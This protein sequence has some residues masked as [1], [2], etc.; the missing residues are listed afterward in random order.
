M[1][2]QRP[3]GIGLP[4]TPV[5]MHD[6]N[7]DEMMAPRYATPVQPTGKLKVQLQFGEKALHVIIIEVTRNLLKIAY[8]RGSRGGGHGVQT[9]LPLKEHKNIGFLSITGLDSLKNHRAT[10]LA[11]NVGPPSVR[12]RNAIE[13]A[14]R[15]WTDD[16][17]L[18]VGFFGS[19]L[20]K[21]LGSAHGF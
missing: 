4:D 13:M 2:F 6:L 8:M 18:L 12:Q 5:M 14:F 10:K 19:P 16:G 9:P 1:S 20:A 11:F 21:L 17:P 7:L 15:W 3:P